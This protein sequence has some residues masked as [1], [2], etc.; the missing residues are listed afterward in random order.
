MPRYILLRVFINFWLYVYYYLSSAVQEE[1]RK[2][3]TVEQIFNLRI[4]QTK[5]KN[6][7]RIFSTC[8]PSGFEFVKKY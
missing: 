8:I 6:R 4:H 1:A 5:A 2:G 3:T 7:P